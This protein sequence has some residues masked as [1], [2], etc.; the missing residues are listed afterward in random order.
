MT[1]RLILAPA[2]VELHND[3][4]INHYI[5]FSVYRYNIKSKNLIICGHARTLRTIEKLSLLLN[6]GNLGTEDKLIEPR[7]NYVM[8]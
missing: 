5:A 7:Y 6:S 3:K 2:P 8:L 1:A 4:Y